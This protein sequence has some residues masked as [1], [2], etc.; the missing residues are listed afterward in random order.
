MVVPRGVLRSV[1]YGA[2]AIAVALALWSSALQPG[3]RVRQQV[4]ALP[5]LG[6]EVLHGWRSL[7]RWALRG[8]ELWRAIRGSPGAVSAR[9]AALLVVRQLAAHAPLPTG[10]L[11]HDASIGALFA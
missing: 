11:V 6:E 7:R 5:S 1:R 8:A 9:D 10:E 3:W 2:V 4:S